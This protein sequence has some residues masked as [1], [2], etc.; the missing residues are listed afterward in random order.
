[1]GKS[2]E[3]K[4]KRIPTYQASDGSSLLSGNTLSNTKSSYH[5]KLKSEQ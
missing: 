5:H 4:K 1:M 3:M 2:K